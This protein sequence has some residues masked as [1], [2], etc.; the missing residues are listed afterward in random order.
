MKTF[1]EFLLEVQKGLFKKPKGTGKEYEIKNAEISA[2]DNFTDRKNNIEI[3]ATTHAKSQAK[4]RR[5]EFTKSD[6]EDLHKKT[7]KLIDDEGLYDD[8]WKLFYSKSM[9]QGYISRLSF[10]GRNNKLTV[11]VI[12]V[13]PKGKNNPKGGNSGG[14]TELELMESSIMESIVIYDMD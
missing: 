12:T 10:N 8:G 13:L 14:T 7:V 2:F 1:K 5:P 4:D 9:K 11:T 6:W 3:R